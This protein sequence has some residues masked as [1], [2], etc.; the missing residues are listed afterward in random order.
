MEFMPNWRAGKSPQF[1]LQAIQ[2][3]ETD[4]GQARNLQ[5]SVLTSTLNRPIQ[6]NCRIAGREWQAL[7]NRTMTQGYSSNSS[8][9]DWSKNLGMAIDK[10]SLRDIPTRV[11]ISPHT[12]AASQIKKKAAGRLLLAGY[13]DPES[14]R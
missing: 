3:R 12:I 6:S 4:Q 9:I 8:R 11:P 1:V 5:F 14:H 10:M 2:N 7:R 13:T